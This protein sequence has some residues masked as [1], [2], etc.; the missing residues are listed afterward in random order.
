[1]FIKFEPNTSI[2]L[3]EFIKY[4]SNLY[5]Y[6]P[7]H[8]L[9]NK[10]YDDIIGKKVFHEQ[11]ILSLFTWKN[12]MT[13]SGKKEITVKQINQNI[14]LIN[15]LKQ[16]GPFYNIDKLTFLPHS[17]WKIYLLH[18]I[19]PDYYPIL[20]QH[21]YRAYQYINSQ[22][23]SEI[24]KD[25]TK[26]ME[27]YLEEYTPYIHQLVNQT[28][29][30]YKKIELVSREIDKSL[31]AFGKFLKSPYVNMIPVRHDSLF[32]MNMLSSLYSHKEN[33]EYDFSKPLQEY[34]AKHPHLIE[35]AINLLEKRDQLIKATNY[36]ERWRLGYY[37]MEQH[38]I[39]LCQSLYPNR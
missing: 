15:E 2:N 39:Q 8:H 26:M 6:K 9:G 31:F 25:K 20:D 12:G 35:E 27:F 17:I 7:H 36:N 5:S 1:M 22:L 28:S 38:D 30:T 21:T 29:M 32:F 24:P 33:G 13:L 23:I 14:N 34:L 3:D 37:L 16:S 18:I 11:D 19:H 4:W 10:L